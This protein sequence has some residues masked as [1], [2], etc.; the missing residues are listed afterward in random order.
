MSISVEECEKRLA[1]PS[2][3]LDEALANLI[4]RSSIANK[5]ML[6]KYMYEAV[7]TENADPIIRIE[8]VPS[9]ITYIPRHGLVN[10]S[11]YMAFRTVFLARLQFICDYVGTAPA[12]MISLMAGG[13]SGGNIIPMF[14]PNIKWINI[15]PNFTPG[16]VPMPDTYPGVK[17]T[18]YNPT[19]GPLTYETAKK[20]LPKVLTDD[21]SNSFSISGHMSNDLAR[22]IN[23][24]FGSDRVFFT[25][26]FRTNAFEDSARAKVDPMYKPPYPDTADL[27]YNMAML[28]NWLRIIQPKY[29]M[30]KFRFP[31]YDESPDVLDELLKRDYVREVFKSAETEINGLGGIDFVKNAKNKQIEFFA[32][33][34]CF[35]PWSVTNTTEVTLYTDCKSKV[36]YESYSEHDSRMLL[37]NSVYR[38]WRHCK[39]PNANDELGFDNCNE[40]ATENL[41]LT[42]WIELYKDN[43]LVSIAVP[44]DI[45]GLLRLIASKTDTYPLKHNFHGSFL[46]PRSGDDMKQLIQTYD[47]IDR[48]RREKQTLLRSLGN[49]TSFAKVIDPAIPVD[50]KAHA[51]ITTLRNDMPPLNILAT[52][53]T[54][55]KIGSSEFDD[56]YEY[57]IDVDDVG[58]ADY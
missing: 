36:M 12:I 56:M 8:D 38:A 21:V 28:Y 27:T 58:A 16:S 45:P 35:R 29:A 19:H 44:F 10:M 6:F 48:E 31:F 17:R 33:E 5:A 22:A 46:K 49:A 54:Q 23:E 34:R 2:S 37:Y 24:V 13:L 52:A 32:G 11:T 4:N 15:N 30:V 41:L 42:K 9:D 51:A 57:E 47:K 14:T 25:S 43:P 50:I 1:N 3:S 7:N 53:P 26:T 40:C 55:D 20:F 39:N 18:L